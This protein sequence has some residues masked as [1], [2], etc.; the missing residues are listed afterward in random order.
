MKFTHIVPC[1]SCQQVFRRFSDLGYLYCGHH[2]IIA[3]RHADAPVSFLPV[4]ST[5]QAML[6]IEDHGRVAGGF[7]LT[8]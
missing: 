6:V 7:S 4:K 5:A 2:R 3:L 1:D 8:A